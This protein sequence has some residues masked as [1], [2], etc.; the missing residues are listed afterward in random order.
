MFNT[1]KALQAGKLDKCESKFAFPVMR[2]MSGAPE[3]LSI[4][5]K[6]DIAFYKIKPKMIFS[7]LAACP[8][9]GFI[10][11]PKK[12]KKQKDDFM[13]IIIPY[14]KKQYGWSEREFANNKKIIEILLERP[15]YLEELNKLF[16]FNKAECKKLDIKYKVDK[17]EFKTG[18]TTKD[19]F[20]F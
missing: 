4:C 13:D 7:L 16:G 6:A 3:N 1:F 10:K 20:S 9:K 2:W 5:S 11:Y 8:R 12:A 17:Y 18:P 15:G 14:I 19:L